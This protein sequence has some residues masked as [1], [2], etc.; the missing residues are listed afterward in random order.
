MLLIFYSRRIHQMEI[1]PPTHQPHYNWSFFA[2]LK[3][4]SDFRSLSRFLTLSPFPASTNS[5]KKPAS[6]HRDEILYHSLNEV[7]V[8]RGFS[9][10]FLVFF[11]FRFFPFERPRVKFIIKRREKF[12]K[13][14]L[15]WLFSGGLE[16]ADGKISFIFSTIK[17]PTQICSIHCLDSF[18]KK[19]KLSS[20][21]FFIFWQT[22]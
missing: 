15:K 22:K 16:R 14:A 7:K 12:T 20:A 4:F 10:L 9:C 1:S 6:L 13:R 8:N 3:N 5:S 21:F 17:R 2:M 11:S 19:K 18:T